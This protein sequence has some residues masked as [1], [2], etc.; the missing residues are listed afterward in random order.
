[1]R[2]SRTCC[3]F[4][5]L[6]PWKLPCK[7]EQTTQK[8]HAEYDNKT[9]ESAKRKLRWIWHIHKTS[10]VA[11]FLTLHEIFQVSD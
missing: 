8:P 9:T 5:N 1:M 4:R 11:S 6:R 2:E 7:V 10:T 3:P